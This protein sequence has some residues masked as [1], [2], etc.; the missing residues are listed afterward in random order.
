[1]IRGEPNQYKLFD[2]GC[3][4]RSDKRTYDVYAL[5]MGSYA[6]NPFDIESVRFG[7]HI[8]N[9]AAPEYDPSL[10]PVS[11][12]QQLDTEIIYRDDGFRE[13]LEAMIRPN[14]YNRLNIIQALKRVN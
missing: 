9:L 14:N 2:F 4:L 5:G 13:T 11:R 6:Q 3:S 12:Q 7:R 8:L 10:G 1:M